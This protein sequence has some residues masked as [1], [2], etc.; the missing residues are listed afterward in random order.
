[1]LWKFLTGENQPVSDFLT[2][3][4]ASIFAYH[5]QVGLPRGLFS[6]GPLTKIVCVYSIYKLWSVLINYNNILS[7]QLAQVLQRFLFVEGSNISCFSTW[8]GNIAFRV[9]PWDSSKVLWTKHLNNSEGHA[10]MVET[11]GDWKEE[12]KDYNWR[13][14]DRFYFVVRGSPRQWTKTGSHTHT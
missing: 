8:C 9:A 1:M 13:S 6:S 10:A 11:S 7:N 4:L 12:M 14:I 2:L 3:F 5:L